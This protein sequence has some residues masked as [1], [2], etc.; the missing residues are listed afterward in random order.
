MTRS[1]A[2]V[3][4]L[5]W[6]GLGGGAHAR[7]AAT[8]ADAQGEL[9]GRVLLGELNCTACH[10]A[11][12]QQASWLSPK[13]GPRLTGIGTRVT[14]EWLQRYL[15]APHATMPGTSMPDVLDL[16]APAERAAGAE[17]LTHYL[18]SP[19][20][21]TFTRVTTDRAAAARGERLYHR[22]GC[23]ACHAPQNP[24]ADTTAVSPLPRIVEKWS[25]D[26]L[27]QFLRDPLASR[28]S[29]RMP[30]MP[31]SDIEAAD[32]AHYLLRDT[33]VPSTLEVA[34][35]RGR[36]RSLEELDS[37]ELSRTGPATGFTLDAMG[38]ERG[39]ALRFTGWLRVDQPGDYTFHLS[40]TGASR[41]SVGERWL[42]GEDSWEQ[43]S[44]NATGTRRLTA[45]WHPLIV[46][47]VLR[48]LKEP[49]LKVEWEGPGV[50]REVIPASRLRSVPAEVKAPARFVVD[51]AKAAEGR[52][53]YATLGCA[54]CH[55]AAAAPARV[56]LPL[57]ALRLTRGCLAEQPS[58]QAPDYHLD[59]TQRAALQQAL[60]SLNRTDLP[61]PTPQQRLAHTMAT[62]KC[63]VCHVRDGAG[64]VTPARD[65]FFTSNGEDLGDEGRLP[66]RLD[67]VGDRLRPTWLHRV[68]TEG[69]SVRPYLDTRMPQYG[70]AN[71]G[72]LAALFVALDRRAQP[73][74]STP[75][76][77]SVQL[78]AGR[79]IVGTNGLSCIG[80]H[81]FNRQPAHAMSVIDLATTTERLNQDWFYRFLLDPSRTH[82]NTRMPAFWPRGVSSLPSV[83]G[84][85]TERQHAAL[86]T[87]LSEGPRAKFPEGLNR[88]HVE[89]IV[90]G[91]P[92]VYRG[93][94][95][96]AGFRAIAVGYPGRLNAAFDAE[97]MRLALLW[98]GRFL[99]AGPH[100]SVQG[101]GQIRPLE[102]NVVVFPRGPAFAA[103]P[104]ANAPW[105]AEGDKPADLQFRGTQLDAQKRPT[106]LYSLRAVS[107]EDFMSPVVT[108]GRAGLRRTLTLTGPVPDGVYFRVAAGRIAPG[109]GNTWR[110]DGTLTIR[111]SGGGK[112]FTRGRGDRQELLIPVRFAS[113]SQLLEIEYVW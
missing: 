97:E 11:T 92:V 6:V 95:W 85:D 40:A 60:T 21:V 93:K 20:P 59:G 79:A 4:L 39:S 89:L 30:A 108:A 100:W 2:V 26:G 94:L 73:V 3:L 8:A 74:R 18:L 58:G 96:E 69:A 37:A 54:A 19:A 90:G 87:Y 31:L 34:Y 81:R 83:L 57:A 107:V 76:A 47:Y 86:W 80:C 12:K 48:A 101:M 49:A 91:E 5:A 111:V 28:P 65:A 22:V 98:R 105:P 9:A 62:F 16:R 106:L 102:S 75:D 35:Y 113:G 82:P 77:R 61:A 43:G 52:K 46:D 29:G 10:A 56:Q 23:V 67:E 68:L 7:P 14:G 64:G 84:G 72:H 42:L 32:V 17:A 112:A 71:V 13:T 41:L 33:I 66:P 110:L 25:F 103:L 109:R 24:A 50:A 51:A 36:V 53:L 45:G 63:G 55:E 99:N 27:R 70:A 15:A 1:R 78:E 88:E 104:D 38:R 44:V